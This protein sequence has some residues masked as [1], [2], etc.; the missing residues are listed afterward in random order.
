MKLKWA[1]LYDGVV[2]LL[3]HGK[4]AYSRWKGIAH[5]NGIA[6]RTSSPTRL[7][8]RESDTRWKSEAKSRERFATF[9]A[10]RRNRVIAGAI[11]EPKIYKSTVRPLCQKRGT[12]AVVFMRAAMRNRIVVDKWRQNDRKDCEWLA[13]PC[14]IARS[15]FAYRRF[16]RAVHFNSVP[17]IPRRYWI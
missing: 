10:S 7:F 14:Q 11:P 4:S 15:W 12:M 1:T 17:E 6:N 3:A 5:A 9:R 2:S 8:S 16:Q 13:A